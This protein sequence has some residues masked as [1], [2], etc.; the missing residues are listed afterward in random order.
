MGEL[1]K[2]NLTAKLA[3]DKSMGNLNY[4]LEDRLLH[5]INSGVK[6]GNTVTFVRLRPEGNLFYDDDIYYKD[7][8]CALSILKSKGFKTSLIKDFPWPW[9]KP[10][11]LEI[12]W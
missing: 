11:Y 7:I 4:N 6:Q 12:N 8:D 1:N 2:E 9:E 10:E 5:A 3:R